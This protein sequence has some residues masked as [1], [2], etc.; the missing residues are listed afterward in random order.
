[1]EILIILILI[2]INGLFSMSEIALV[3]ARKNRL[4]YS[5]QR[6]NRG[7]KIALD[8]ASNP[9]KLLSTAQ[10]GITLIGI[11]TGIYSGERITQGLEEYFLGFPL[12]APYAHTL[13]ITVVLI[14]LS[15]F[16]LVLGELVPKRIGLTYPETIAKTVA[17]PMKIIGYIMAPFIFLLTNT[18]DLLLKI[19]NVKPSSNSKVTE[20]E[21]KA[22]IKE[23]TEEGEVQ[24][25]EQ[26]IV[27]RVFSVGDRSVSSLMTSRKKMTALDLADTKEEVKKLV[28]HDMHNF[29]PIYD[30]DVQ[31]IVGIVSLKRLFAEIEKDEFNLKNILSEPSYIAEGASAYQALAQFKQ[32][33]IHYAL[34]I[35]EYG[36]T[37]GILTM[38]DILEALVGEVSEFYGQEYRFE[39]RDDNSWLIDGHYPLPDFLIEFGMEDFI[40]DFEVNTVGGLIIQ[41]LGHIPKETE[42]ARWEHFEFEILD[43]DGPKIDKVLVVRKKGE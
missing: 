39:K 17:F 2:L 5:A 36:S 16:A 26:D 4:N 29:Y 7:A 14:I 35:D 30:S 25:I 34:V 27:N 37:Q 43:M 22:I 18:T 24:E 13:S 19:F 6:G 1:M 20:E 15:F 12:F 11:M 42:K 28:S 23:G 9:S 33:N 32:T 8:L 41:V 38:S 40:K 10:I 31:D 21:I 3:S